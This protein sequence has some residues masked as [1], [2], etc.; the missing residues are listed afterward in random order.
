MNIFCFKSTQLLNH[1]MSTLVD[2]RSPR[3][4]FLDGKIRNRQHPGPL[5]VTSGTPEERADFVASVNHKDVVALTPEREFG[6]LCECT[7][8][9][10]NDTK[11]MV[12]VGLGKTTVTL[13]D[14]KKSLS[15]HFPSPAKR[16]E[17]DN[18]AAEWLA[19]WQTMPQSNLV[20][21]LA[22]Q[23]TCFKN[24]FPNG[25]ATKLLTLNELRAIADEDPSFSLGAARLLVHAFCDATSF[26]VASPT[27]QLC[28]RKKRFWMSDKRTLNIFSGGDYE[29]YTNL[30]CAPRYTLTAL[31]AMY[32]V[33]F[34]MFCLFVFAF[35]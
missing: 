29:I 4:R 19:I 11:E 6:A 7:K 9:L 5:N 34:A 24:L 18:I 8:I 10:H 1:T 22:G 30:S 20:C 15:A 12:V 14:R 33:L 16:E 28:N 26:M 3:K 2:G 23:F 13:G 35:V 25:E 21:M 31:G 17:A 27:V 32:I